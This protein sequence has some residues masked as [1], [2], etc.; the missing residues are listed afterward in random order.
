MAFFQNKTFSVIKQVSVRNAKQLRF[1]KKGLCV[2]IKVQILATKLHPQAEYPKR[3]PFILL[4]R[5]YFRDLWYKKL[6]KR[7]RNYS[8]LASLRNKAIY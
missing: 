1:G 7:W 5:F 6:Y 4:I 8:S 3:P 2:S